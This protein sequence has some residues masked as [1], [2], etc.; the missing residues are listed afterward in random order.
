MAKRR[1]QRAVVRLACLLTVLLAAGL[2]C[3]LFWSGGAAPRRLGADAGEARA[4]HG[5]EVRAPASQLDP[6]GNGQRSAGA[7]AG[8]SGGKAS[9]AGSRS[10]RGRGH[11]D[12]FVLQAVRPELTHFTY[13]LEPYRISEVSRADGRYALIEAAHGWPLQ[14]RG[15]PVLPV[16]RAD[17][18]VPE[19]GDYELVVLASEYEDVAC[20][21]PLP[22]SG[23]V[24]RSQ[25]PSDSA[26]SPSVY[27]GTAPYPAQ[28]LTRLQTYRLR[29]VSGVAVQVS[30]F[31]YLPAEGVLRVYTRLEMALRASGSRADDYASR[32]SDWQYA[33]LQDS[34]FLN[35]GLLRAASS[36]AAVGSILLVCPD[37]WKS[38]LADFVTWKERVGFHVTMAGYPGDTGTGSAALQAYV[39]AAYEHDGLSQVLICGDENRVPPQAKSSNTTNPGTLPPTTDIP[40][41]WVDGADVYADLFISR[42]SVETAEALS[43]VLGKLRGYEEQA[44]LTDA[45]PGRGLFVASE[46]QGSSGISDGVKDW[47]LVD[48]CRR[49]LLDAGRIS[50]DSPTAYAPGAT[51]DAVIR[52]LNAG[53]SLVYY[54]GHGQSTYWVT[55]S[56]DSAQAKALSNGR[57][58]PLVV[59]PVCNNGNFAFFSGDC[60]A[61]AFFEAT[62]GGGARHGAA[63]VLAS[64]SETYWNPPIYLLQAITDRLVD[65]TGPARLQS[66]GAYSWAGIFAGIDYAATGS[67]ADEYGF[68][69]DPP[70]YFSRQMHLF[71]DASQVARLQPL[72]PLRVSH[73]LQGAA[74]GGLLLTVSVADEDSS[75]PLAGAAVCA[76]TADGQTLASGRSDADGVVAL[77]FSSDVRTISLSVLDAGAPFYLGE[78]EFGPVLLTPQLWLPRGWAAEAALALS[79]ASAQWQVRAGALPPGIDLSVAGVLSGTAT[80][81]G[82]YDLTVRAELLDG[83]ALIRDYPLRVEVLEPD[84]D[85][86]QTVEFFVGRAYELQVRPSAVAAGS[87]AGDYRCVGIGGAVPAGLMLAADGGLSGRPETAGLSEARCLFAAGGS[88]FLLS[89]YL[90][91]VYAEPDA[92]ADGALSHQELLRFLDDWYAQ[93]GLPDTRQAVLAQWLDSGWVQSRT[94]NDDSDPA[95]GAAVAGDDIPVAPP[96]PWRVGVDIRAAGALDRLAR[97]GLA[98]TAL[99]DGVAWLELSEEQW[100]QLQGADVVL[101]ASEYLP[102]RTR[103]VNA[104]Y[105][106]PEAMN[107]RLLALAASHWSLC[108]PD[109]V[110]RSS[111]GRD[112]LALRIG[113]PKQAAGAPELLITGAIHGDERPGAMLPLRL[114]DYLLAA[115]AAGDA[116]VRAI[117]DQSAVWIMPIVNP[118]GVAVASRTNAN[119]YDLNRNFPDG[120]VIPGLGSYA[121]A[122][123]MYQAG[124]QLETRALMRWSASRRF[125][126]ALHLHTG[127]RLVCYPYGNNA[128]GTTEG[129]VS[130]T[131]D[132]LLYRSLATSYARANTAMAESDIINGSAWYICSGEFAD[133]QYRFLGTLAMTV[134][135]MGS[136]KESSDIAHL[137][138][139]WQENQEALLV[140]LET[141]LTGV[142]GRVTDSVSGQPL[143]QA[144]IQ[145][146]GAQDVNADRQGAYHRTLASGA[147]SV[148]VSAPGYQTKAQTVVITAGV[149]TQVDVAL[150]LSDEYGLQ[151]QFAR[152]RY[153]PTYANAVGWQVRRRDS[154]AALPRALVMSCALP[155]SAW[156]AGLA[157][158][159]IVAAARRWDDATTRSWVLLRDDHG[160]EE[161][162]AD[163]FDHSDGMTLKGVDNAAADAVLAFTLC[164]PGGQSATQRRTWLSAEP[165]T[166]LVS[167]RNG[168]N[169]VGLPLFPCI[170][171]SQPPPWELLWRWTSSGYRLAGLEDLVPPRAAWALVVSEVPEPS[172]VLSG[173]QAPDGVLEYDA[174]WTAF[175]SLWSRPVPALPAEAGM[176][177]VGWR[178][179]GG[180]VPS[181]QLRP[182]MGTWLFSP[183]AGRM[184]VV[185]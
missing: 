47:S 46:Q 92:D 165:I 45:Y 134:E 87:V 157:D 150:S 90:L 7:G 81:A 65:A 31:Q 58:L 172:W 176:R 37:A 42:V 141:A 119:N 148:T 74:D 68:L 32:S 50:A 72:S 147:R 142:R 170:G 30:P 70:G 85:S 6:S 94:A 3:W 171:A 182:G 160:G 75:V 110:G 53:V 93:A 146:V 103:A 4:E 89:R 8:N 34:A 156:A 55:T 17:L 39:R 151:P 16:Y 180:F 43:R 91:R 95:G 88:R 101:V 102:A 15:E 112:M 159:G 169:F 130:A 106:T 21:P 152:S 63:A 167:L 52:H 59:S 154:A 10:G 79:S 12:Q 135:L 145:V 127:A 83:T 113:V 185:E 126:A 71:G 153:V 123:P 111:N 173:W 76:Q 137:D 41:A 73:S 60:L 11:H 80:A 69:A 49:Q 54:L 136:A 28:V 117:L 116:R 82:V 25:Q 178:R 166:A 108:R 96:T 57:A 175:S 181:S 9:P 84:E 131:P 62:D 5:G 138:R 78:I 38:A 114:A 140:W 61:E 133:W 161:Q 18:L 1:R 124:R 107:E 162:R 158:D 36:P 120:I 183:R 40:Y 139:L 115:Y 125:S 97:R 184:D 155:S 128:A 121:A 22:S 48:A 177:I 35:A 122:S 27:Q 23:M 168:W 109:V 144:R 129:Y 44:A 56:F 33:Q 174:G 98:I 13:E 20:L 29:G 179:G 163:V 100:Q 2:G 104:L 86:M 105:L 26:P 24:L 51:A 66:M 64:T 132:H 118:D 149:V 77:A 19:H 143:A 14:H 164:W 67:V 99:H